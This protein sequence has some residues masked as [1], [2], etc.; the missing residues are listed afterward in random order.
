MWYSWRDVTVRKWLKKMELTYRTKG[1]AAF[2]QLKLMNRRWFY[3]IERRQSLFSL[4]D[5]IFC[6]VIWHFSFSSF[7]IFHMGTF[8]NNCVQGNKIVF[9][10]ILVGCVF[11]YLESPRKLIKDFYS[12]IF[13]TV[14]VSNWSTL[15]VAFG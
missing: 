6:I 9:S 10:D 14:Q 11:L 5:Q 3:N 1:G 8:L 12:K 4:P 15:E 7:C 2:W 13:L